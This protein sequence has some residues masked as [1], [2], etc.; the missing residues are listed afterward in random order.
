VCYLATNRVKLAPDM[1]TKSILT[2][3]IFMLKST[4]YANEHIPNDDQ[5]W[6]FDSSTKKLSNKEHSSWLL[7]DKTWDIPT[8]GTEGYITDTFS[9]QVLTLKDGNDEY[10]TE[11]QLQDKKSPINSFTNYTEDQKWYRKWW[12]TFDSDY[13]VLIG[14]QTKRLLTAEG[15]EKLFIGD[16]AEKKD[17]NTILRNL[18]PIIQG[19]VWSLIIIIMISAWIYCLCCRKKARMSAEERDQLQKEKWENKTNRF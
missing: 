13:F 9:G 14:G 5:L 1:K 4:A 7:M 11:V 16:F 18:G 3:L 2:C 12:N 10:E 15:T 19:C 8:N 6:S 17:E